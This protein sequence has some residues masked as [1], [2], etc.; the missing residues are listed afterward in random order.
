MQVFTKV[1]SVVD[2]TITTGIEKAKEAQ[3]PEKAK[4]GA[5]SLLTRLKNGW[6]AAT[7]PLDTNT[8]AS[9]ITKEQILKEAAEARAKI[10]RDLQQRLKQL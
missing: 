1:G 4:A 9:T 5:K 10:E 6:K 7:G 3:L 8:G 2:S